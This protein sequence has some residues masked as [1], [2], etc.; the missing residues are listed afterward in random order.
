[1]LA[2]AKKLLSLEENSIFNVTPTTL[3]GTERLCSNAVGYALIGE[4]M[5][6][7]R[8]KKLNMLVQL[9]LVRSWTGRLRSAKSRFL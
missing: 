2:K 8:C 3:P 4:Y 9:K 5:H 1:M 6:A 7:V